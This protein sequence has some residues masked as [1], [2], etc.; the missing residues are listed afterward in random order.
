MILS[1]IRKPRYI[2]FAVAALAVLVSGGII[3][4]NLLMGQTRATYE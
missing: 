3:T 2:I 4:S 1:F